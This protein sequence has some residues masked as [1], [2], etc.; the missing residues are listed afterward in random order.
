[1]VFIP[2]LKGI[3]M[4]QVEECSLKIIREAVGG[5]PEIFSS[6]TDWNNIA[7][8]LA[9]QAILPLAYNALKRGCIPDGDFRRE[10]ISKI[11]Y[12]IS[13]WYI[14][15][16]HQNE[17]V[18]ILRDSGYKFV[19]MKGFANAFLYPK[20]ELRTIGDVDFLVRIDEFDEIYQLLQGKGYQPSGD[21]DG[22]KHH[23]N[24]K[25]DGVLFEM[26]KRPAGTMRKFSGN[27]QWIIEYF[28]DGLNFTESVELYGY[29]FPVFDPVRNGL[30]LLLHTAGHMQEGIGV[31]HLLDWGMYADRYLSDDLWNDEFH[32]MASKL[33]VDELAKIMTYICQ[34]ELGLCACRDWCK[35]ADGYTAYALLEYMVAQGNFG[36]KAGET[37]AGAK[38]FTESLDSEGFFR[39]LDRSSRYSFPIV[40]KYPLLRPVG[41]IYQ[42]GRY[43]RR[44]M[45]Q[46]IIF[47]NLQEDIETGKQRRRLM[48]N[49]GIDAW[50]KSDKR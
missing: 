17:L 18:Q 44:G 7:M 27:N 43:L 42:F 9:N 14:M 45:H 3:K 36:R 28:E 29:S 4:Q 34:K 47:G 8:E 2:N 13:N 50:M 23:M 31:R 19:I 40:N 11:I 25:K 6:A 46:E 21:G 41:W 48:Q 22:G 39:R 12:Q 15:L 49:L 20:P 32:Q 10:W 1:M 26:H 16:E 38:F 37:D 24:L 5:K 33:Q 30:M 35:D